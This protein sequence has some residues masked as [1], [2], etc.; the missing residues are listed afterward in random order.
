MVAELAKQTYWLGE[1]RLELSV[2][3]QG[4]I[5]FCKKSFRFRLGSGHRCFPQPICKI[6]VNM[7][8]FLKDRGEHK[9]DV[10]ETTFLVGTFFLSRDLL[11]FTCKY[12]CL[13]V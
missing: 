5:P 10:N 4:V 8:I 12:Q 3:C 2:R 1:K 6:S 9:K 13:K 7:N 11:G